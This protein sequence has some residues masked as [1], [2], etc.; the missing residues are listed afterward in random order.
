MTWKRWRD[1][2]LCYG[3]HS[4]INYT[5]SVS[6]S[7]GCAITVDTRKHVLFAMLLCSWLSIFGWPK[8]KSVNDYFCYITWTFHIAWVLFISFADKRENLPPLIYIFSHF[9]FLLPFS[10]VSSFSSWIFLLMMIRQ[11]DIFNLRL[12]C[13][14]PCHVVVSSQFTMNSSKKSCLWWWKTGKSLW[15]KTYE[16][17]FFNYN[18]ESQSRLYTNT[19]TH[20]LRRK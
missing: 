5:V 12:P 17:I 1:I 18:C 10:L 2:I 16:N 20:I 14:V 19:S 8:V 11:D 3:G 15:T 4:K 13:R 9:Q 6:A 7:C